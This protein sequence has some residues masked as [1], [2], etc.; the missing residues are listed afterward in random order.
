MERDLRRIEVMLTIRRFEERL[1]QLHQEKAFPG[2]YHVYIGQ[3]ATGAAVAEALGEGDLVFTTHRN[4]GHLLARGADIGRV[5]A[6]IFGK[7]GGYNQGKGGT[8][9]VASPE[10]GILSTSAIVG[11]NLPIA[12]GAALSL[13]RFSKSAIVVSFFGDGVLEEGAFYE[14]INLAGVWK[15][16]ILFVCENNSIPPDQRRLGQYPSS[17]NAAPDLSAVPGSF[18]IP[19]QAWDGADAATLFG[20]FRE[21]VETVRS[22]QLPRFVEVRNTRWPGSEDLWPSLANGPTDLGLVWSGVEPS[23]MGNWYRDSDPLLRY[24]QQVKNEPDISREVLSELDQ[25]VRERI[26]T[27]VRFAV[28]SPYPETSAA[29]RDVFAKGGSQS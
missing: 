20:A 2:H 11:G 15:V 27:G 5:M 25:Q 28:D 16:P 3:E 4:H 22:E 1:I 18:G 19:S 26:E 13:K 6:E 21:L 12:V 17:T 8:L 14:A 29:Y 9:H 10:L 24:I 7:A 23:P